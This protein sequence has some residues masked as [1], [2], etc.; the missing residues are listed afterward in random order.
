TE[1]VVCDPP[2]STE[3][4][5][6]A[7]SALRRDP[8]VYYAPDLWADAAESAGMPGPVVRGLRA[9]ESWAMA[10]AARV[11]AVSAPAAARLAEL[12]VERG[13]AV[14]HGVRPDVLT[15]CVPGPPGDR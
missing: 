6:R 7:V 1:D 10:G 4:V 3:A 13:E 14:P 5:V 8:Y 2:P 11:L 9:V 12:G 15:P